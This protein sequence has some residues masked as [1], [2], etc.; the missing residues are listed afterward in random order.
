ML[1]VQNVEAALR[2]PSTPHGQTS[3]DVS[4][5]LR[6]RRCQDDGGFRMMLY[7]EYLK[8][9]RLFSWE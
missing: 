5:L 1:E 7:K 6:G 8:E 2:A 4:A 3:L 9:V